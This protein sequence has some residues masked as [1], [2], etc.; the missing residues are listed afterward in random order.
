MERKIPTPFSE[1]PEGAAQMTGKTPEEKALFANTQVSTSRVIHTPSAFARENLL[2]LQEVGSLRA[3]APHISRRENLPSYLFFLVKDGEGT[4]RYGGRQYC[5]GPGDCVFIDCRAGYAQSTSDHRDESG[6]YDKLWALSWV[7]FDGPT[8]AGIYEKY[9]ERGGQPVF[10][11]ASPGRRE[12]YRA[13][14][15]AVLRLA[16][17]DSYV[18][19]MQIAEKLTELLTCLMEDAWSPGQTFIPG[20]KRLSVREVRAYI[21]EH[22]GEKLSLDNLSK[23]FFINKYYLAKIFKE[24]YG[25]TVNACI[26]QVRIGK[27]KELLRFSD[28][29]V[30][31]IGFECGFTDPNYFARCFKKVEGISPSEYRQRW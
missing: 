29:T 7:H 14:L 11:C 4:L 31:A 24:Q 15:D 20:T 22:Y 17:A 27:A 19:D 9:R 23:G 12:R 13:L 26:A 5:L 6:G 1:N 8:M 25:Y 16:A 10:S 30:E 28:R 2:Y 3:L 18:R 21:G